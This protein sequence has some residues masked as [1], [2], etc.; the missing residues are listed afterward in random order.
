[1]AFLQQSIITLR[2]YQNIIMERF[3]VINTN[4]DITTKLISFVFR[5]YKS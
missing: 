4:E 3:G 2:A 5:D 1:M